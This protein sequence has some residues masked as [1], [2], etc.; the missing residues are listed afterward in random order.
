MGQSNGGRIVLTTTHLLSGGSLRPFWSEP[1]VQL[2]S[3]RP[4]LRLR[5]VLL[6][7]AAGHHWLNPGERLA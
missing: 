4:D 5:A 7:A 3:G 1:E 2:T 6:D